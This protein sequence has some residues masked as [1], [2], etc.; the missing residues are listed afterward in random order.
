VDLGK[1]AG[2]A[3]GSDA[4]YTFRLT[5]DLTGFDPSSALLSGSWEADNTGF[6]L[7]NGATPSGTGVFELPDVS[8]DNFDRFHDFSITGGF[9]SGLSTLDFVVTDA[10]NLGAFGLTNLVGTATP[11]GVPEPASLAMLGMG[12]IGLL[13]YGRRQRRAI[14][15]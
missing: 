9:V 6:I 10:D 12:A 3:C 5:F 2:R 13:G 11:T 7:L 4:T 8:T 1:R 14:P 15:A